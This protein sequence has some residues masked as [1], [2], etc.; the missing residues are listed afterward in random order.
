MGE[1][2]QDAT[3]LYTA[4]SNEIMNWREYG[5]YCSWFKLRHYSRIYLEGLRKSTKSLIWDS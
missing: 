5:S 1:V 4:E 3:I 2:Q